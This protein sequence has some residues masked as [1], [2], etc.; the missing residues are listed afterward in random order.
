MCLDVLRYGIPTLMCC[1]FMF[2]F[3]FKGQNPLP[4]CSLCHVEVKKQLRRSVTAHNRGKRAAAKMLDRG[5]LDS[6]GHDAWK[7]FQNI[8]WHILYMLP[9]FNIAPE[10]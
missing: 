8:S 2:G 1:I 5:I 7:K 4:I 3:G 10:K 9:K 6:L